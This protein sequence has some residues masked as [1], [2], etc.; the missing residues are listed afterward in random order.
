MSRL[1]DSLK[2]Y[3]NQIKQLDI[4]AKKAKQY[5]K[6]QEDLAKYEIADI[7]NNLARGYEQLAILK[8]DLEPKIREFETLNT[9]LSQLEA[10]IEDLRLT[11]VENNDRYV[12][13]NS[14]LSDF[15]TSIA[16]ADSKI[17][18]LRQKDAEL[19]AE[20]ERL[21]IEIEDAQGKILKYENDI[22]T[23]NT[24]D[25]GIEEEVE[26]LKAECSEKEIRYNSVKE[27]LANLEK[28]EDDIR[29]NLESL[30]Q[31][32]DSLINSKTSVFQEQADAKRRGR[33]IERTIIRMQSE[34]EP[35]T[36]EIENYEQTL[37]QSKNFLVDW[38]K[39][40]RRQNR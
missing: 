37:L 4:Q 17:G 30:D 15:K 14:E 12:S 32:K 8:K 39:K 11:Q 38:K 20:Q 6:Y 1:D 18:N 25:D 35:S 26:R 2:I 22:A 23:I 29:N 16:L 31:T 27:Q 28:Q 5:K 36:Q 3:E 10:E 9:S 21:R 33:S 24:N 19:I 13:L 40:S 7:V 34:I